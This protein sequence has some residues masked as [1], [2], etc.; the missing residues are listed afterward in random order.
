MWFSVLILNTSL[1]FDSFFFKFNFTIVILNELIRVFVKFC[2]TFFLHF[3]YFKK[4]GS[5]Y[6]FKKLHNL[7]HRMNDLAVCAAFT[8]ILFEFH[9]TRLK[10]QT[11]I[12][13]LNYNFWRRQTG[14]LCYTS[15]MWYLR[16]PR[17][18][19]FLE[20]LLWISFL[21]FFFFQIILQ[22]FFLNTAS[23]LSFPNFSYHMLNPVLLH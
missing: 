5:F 21:V 11:I 2:F 20:L 12:N 3:R 7:N 22:N 1:L 16:T 9:E 4:P 18:Y 10:P 14:C 17:I 15:T 23:K 19:L 8:S 6:F 13:F